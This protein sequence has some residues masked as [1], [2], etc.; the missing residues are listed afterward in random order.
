M[1]EVSV[2]I[3]CLNEEQSIASC[4]RKANE[5]FAKYKGAGEV[6]VVDNGSTDQSVA[7]AR[8]LGARVIVEERKGYGSALR[9]GIAAAQGAFIAMGDGDDTYDF[10][11][12]DE[13]F[14]RLKQG[15]DLV[16]GS[17]FKGTI[18]PGAMTWSH[19]Y[20]GNPIL[21]GML[22]LFFGGAVSDAHCGLRAFRKTAYDL[23]D[24]HTTG[25]EFASEMVI[26]SLKKKLKISEIPITYYPRQ[27]ES[28]LASFR[29]AWRHMRFMLIYSPGYLYVL[30]GLI[31]FLFSF[32]VTLRL[33]AGPIVAFG[34]G[35]EIHVMVFSSMFTILGW[36][37]INLGIAAKVFAYSISLEEDNWI[38]HVLKLVT[39][40]RAIVCGLGLVIAGMGMIGYIFYVWSQNHFG[41]LKEVNTGLFALTLTVL[42]FQTIFTAFLTS[43]LQIK[44]R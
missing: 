10:S 8:S 30:P 41:A 31:L 39:L 20:I 16:M 2:V 19:R 13:F 14:T 4:I 34:R 42:G 24:L 40:E 35:W 1:I 9:T 12:A 38:Q 7:I 32:L 28:K 6:I 44:F 43:M 5:A 11:T 15:Y 3:P 26:H 27:G 37:I 36:Q 21:S 33:L 22:K 25:M 23:M 17:R 18:V 29:D